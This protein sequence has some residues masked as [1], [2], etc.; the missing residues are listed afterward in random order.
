[1]LWVLCS[2]QCVCVFA[3]VCVCCVVCVC[4]RVFVC[5]CVCLC[6]H[7]CVCVCVCVCVCSGS[8]LVRCRSQIWLLSRRKVC[9]VC[10]CG[11]NTWKKGI[12]K[13]THSR[14][15]VQNVRPGLLQ[16]HRSLAAQ[17]GVQGLPGGFPAR[18]DDDEGFF[19][20]H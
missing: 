2:V 7:A 17:A 6:V 15:F 14:P 13:S 1:M 18:D 19:F 9:V 11:A 3:C 5:V 20:F 12:N 10:M 4:V 16:R 8:G